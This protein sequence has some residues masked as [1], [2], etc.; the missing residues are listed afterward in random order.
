MPGYFPRPLGCS[1]VVSMNEA[2]TPEDI[3]REFPGWHAWRGVNERWY[4]RLPR[5]PILSLQ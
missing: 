1:S 3:E 4:A 2:A 5:T